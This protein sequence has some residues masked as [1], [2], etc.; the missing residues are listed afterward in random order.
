MHP[1]A[2]AA[3][4][5]SRLVPREPSIAKLWNRPSNDLDIDVDVDM[6]FN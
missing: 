3:V 2:T 4:R 6:W 5:M 1:G